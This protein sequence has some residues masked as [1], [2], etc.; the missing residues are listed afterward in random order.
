MPV[1]VPESPVLRTMR[2]RR[3]HETFISIPDLVAYLYQAANV[4][5]Q[6]PDAAMAFRLFAES[7]QEGE[8]TRL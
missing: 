6:A 8:P 1:I 3:T 2:S 5:G 7:I 4:L